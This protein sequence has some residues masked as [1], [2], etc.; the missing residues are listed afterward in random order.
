MM[1]DYLLHEGAIVL[2]L[3]PPGLARPITTSMRV[4]VSGQSVATQL[5][6]YSITGCS[7][8]SSGSPPC[9]IASWITA[10][11]RVRADGMPVLLRNSQ[12]MCTPTGTGLN[13]VQTQMRVRGT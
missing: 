4:K 13:I 8:S 9:V 1:A 6:P 3:H 11:G 7:L 5:A 10:A 2:C 12:A